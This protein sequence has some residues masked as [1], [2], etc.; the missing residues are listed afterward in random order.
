MRSRIVLAGLVLLGS[1]AACTPAT[2]HPR[3]IGR[4]AVAQQVAVPGHL[5][6]TKGRR[7]YRLAGTTMTAVTRRD[8]RVQD[9]ATTLDGATLAFA[10]LGQDSSV[11]EVSDPQ[12][13]SW[14][15]LTDASGPEGA[16]WAFSPSFAPDGRALAFLTDRGKGYSGPPDLG[17]WRYD[18]VRHTSQQLARPYAY[19][20]GDG[21]PAWRPNADGQL[22]YVTY[23]YAGEPAAPAARLTWHSAASGRT[24]FVS[25]PTERN[26]EAAWSP[27]GRFVAYIHAGPG[28]DELY[29]MPVPPAFAGE[30][31]PY[32]TEGA[33]LLQA[34]IIAEPV[35]AP[36]GSALAFLQLVDGSFDLYMLPVATNGTVHT[37]GPPV[38][39]TKGSFLDADSRLAWS[40]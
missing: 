21:G 28:S 24:I 8:L 12:L 7:L 9:P 15:T 19:T 18:L 4:V 11:I 22:L 30:P 1:T 35:W 40:L 13:S 27:D 20:G 2:A 10:L 31:H 16:L 38:A 39:L 26:F 34:G 25:P 32:P 29:V 17:V 37:A 3:D 5:Y 36:D 14:H 23:L 6:V 33:T